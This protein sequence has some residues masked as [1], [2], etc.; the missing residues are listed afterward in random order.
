MSIGGGQD[1]GFL[2]VEEASK[3]RPYLAEAL[4]E[5]E[6]VP[7]GGQGGDGIEVPK[8]VGNVAIVLVLV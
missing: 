4:T 6:E 8:H 5:E 1:P 7:K 2:W 3:Q